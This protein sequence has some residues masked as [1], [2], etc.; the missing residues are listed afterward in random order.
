MDYNVTDDTSASLVLTS[1]LRTDNAR[2]R[3]YALADNIHVLEISH[4]G[5][6]VA[7]QLELYNMICY[8]HKY[9]RP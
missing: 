6:V 4:N 2:I 9:I 3:A 7:S 1:S 5:C 8:H